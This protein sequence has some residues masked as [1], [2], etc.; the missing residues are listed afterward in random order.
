MLGSPLASQQ[1]FLEAATLCMFR[2]IIQ[3]PY[4]TKAGL[5]RENLSAVNH[6]KN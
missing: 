2:H 5:F 6:D 4:K 1:I 3:F